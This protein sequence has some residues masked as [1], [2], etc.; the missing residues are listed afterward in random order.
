MKKYYEK[1]LNEIESIVEKINY[2]SYISGLAYWDMAVNMPKEA[3]KSRGETLGFLSSELY[4]LITNDRTYNLLCELEDI[5]DL[6]LEEAAMIKNLKEESDKT[7]K[8]PEDIYK[9]FSIDAAKS[10]IA[11]QDAKSKNDFSIFMPHLEKMVDYKRKFANFYGYEKHPYDALLNEYEMGMTVE[12]L[13]KVFALLRDEIVNILSKVKESKVNINENILKG[14][15]S[16]EKQKELE[17]YVL[18]LIGYDYK[19]KGRIDSSEHPFTTNFGNKDV[20]ITNHYHDDNFYSAMYSAIHEGGHAIY[21]Q[22]IS[23][24]LEKYGLQGGVSMGIHES[25]SRF[26]ENIIGKSKE[27]L[28]LVYPK[29]Q[30]L[31]EEFKSVSFED[32][33]KVCNIACPSLIRTEAD[34]LTYSLHVII[35]YEIE[36]ELIKGDI[37]VK[38]LKDI[39][40]NKY[41]EY[42]G[43]RPQND[44]EGILQDLH[45]SDGEFGYFPSYALGNI[46]GAQFL[47][48]A[49]K[50]MPNLYNEIEKG[51]LNG[52]KVWLKENIHQYG[53]LYKPAELLKKVTGE[54]L[55]SKYFVEYLRNKFK[56]VYEF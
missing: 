6:T 11:W 10:E 1:Q 15:F 38:D 43:V 9:N 52:I 20:R 34:E 37:E 48:A 31:F 44:S 21:E 16:I 29:V 26:Y 14:K 23:D 49:L 54:E 47:N 3:G 12:K 5:S 27:F 50:D 17:K 28:R 8:I 4:K 7:K 30:E 51:N 22:Q 33:Y 2:F 45:W 36:K 46:Y 32:F 39:W 13:D 24:D 53:K 55:D 41:E 25:Q 42:L 56:D 18:D 35:R 19:N 40:N